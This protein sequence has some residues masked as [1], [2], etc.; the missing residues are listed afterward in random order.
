M[1]NVDNSKKLRLGE[2]RNIFNTKKIWTSKK[3]PLLIIILAGE[4][5]IDG[6]E[7][8]L[9]NLIT[10]GTFFN[11]MVTFAAA[12]GIAGRIFCF[13]SPKKSFNVVVGLIGVIALR[14][15][16]VFFFFKVSR[17]L[18]LE[19]QAFKNGV[20]KYFGGIMNN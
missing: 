16:G 18:V 13:L 9:G 15:R 2:D 12:I 19:Y 14:L 10:D 20:L 6:S 8:S 1:I 17:F 3:L 4:G 5:S 7:F 11:G